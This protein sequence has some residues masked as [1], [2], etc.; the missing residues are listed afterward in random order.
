[1]GV[2]FAVTYLLQCAH[3][4]LDGGGG[5]ARMF[6]YLFSAFNSFKPLLLKRRLLGM[7]VSMST[8]FWVTDYLLDRPQ[9]VLLWTSV[10]DVV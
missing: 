3:S 10:S 7:S 1:M 6:L 4:Y 9:F 8:A 5:T 2:D